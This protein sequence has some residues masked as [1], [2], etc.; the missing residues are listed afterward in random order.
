MIDSGCFRPD[1]VPERSADLFLL[2][3]GCKLYGVGSH[4][5]DEP[6]G[7]NPLPAEG[8]EPSKPELLFL[9]SKPAFYLNAPVNPDFH[10]ETGGELLIG[11]L[12]PLPMLKHDLKTFE[13]VCLW[14]AD[15]GF[16]VG[17][18]DATP[19]TFIDSYR[20][21]LVPSLPCTGEDQFAVVLADEVASFATF[22]DF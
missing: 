4:A 16:P 18:G 7:E 1:S 21:F 5:A 17:T 12:L 8:T 6:F 13:P 19:S 10:S 14:I 20:F 15:A 11:K 3:A 22:I 2:D 9:E